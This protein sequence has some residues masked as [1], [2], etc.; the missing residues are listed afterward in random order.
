[1]E[2]KSSAATS[3]GDPEG[4]DVADRIGEATRR[5]ELEYPD[6]GLPLVDRLIN[7]LVEFVGVSVLVGIV[8]LVFANAVSRYGA[9]SAISWTEEAVQMAMPWL[10]MTGVFLSVRRGSMIRIDYFYE[11]LP[12][13]LR[14]AVAD[15][16]YVVNIGVLL[17]MAYVSLDYVM[18]FGGDVALYA[19]IPMA[20]STS[21]L[22]FG[23]LG[24]A[25]AFLAE[26][27]SH[28]RVR[29]EQAGAAS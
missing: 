4:A 27:R 8:G 17:F 13:R 11:L 10:A 3:G 22:V 28:R 19:E 15:F 2:E 12:E 1:M 29:A 16:G 25:M 14:G 6:R 26:F 7:G 18:R 5:I 21:A 20:W 24:A 9:G 23:S